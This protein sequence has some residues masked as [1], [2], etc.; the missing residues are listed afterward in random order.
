MCFYYRIMMTIHQMN[1]TP[2][3]PDGKFIFTEEKNGR[4]VG[5]MVFPTYSTTMKGKIQLLLNDICMDADFE[6]R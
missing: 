3:V 6:M 1:F 2:E 5:K 4:L